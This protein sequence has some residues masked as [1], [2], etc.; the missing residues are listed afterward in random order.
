MYWHTSLLGRHLLQ[1]CVC[2]LSY[3]FVVSTCSIASKKAMKLWIVAWRRELKSIDRHGQD[4]KNIP[5]GANMGFIFVTERLISSPPVFCSSKELQLPMIKNWFKFLYV[6]ILLV[7]LIPTVCI[8]SYLANWI[9]RKNWRLQSIKGFLYTSC[10]NVYTWK[11]LRHSVIFR[12][13][14]A[15]YFIYIVTPHQSTQIWKL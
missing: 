11:R 3:E 14:T 1:Y 13:S 7:K 6:I 12:P 9:D 5:L 4:Y 10:I 15:L 8:P 2:S